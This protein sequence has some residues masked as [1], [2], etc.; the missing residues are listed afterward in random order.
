MDLTIV[1]TYWMCVDLLVAISHREDPQCQMT[2][3]Q[4]MTT[5]MV[6]ALYFGGNYELARHFLKSEGY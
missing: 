1:M 6:A 5:A 3:A 2:D 4:V